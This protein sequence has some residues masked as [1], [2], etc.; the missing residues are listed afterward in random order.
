[1]VPHHPE[2]KS[3]KPFKAVLA[4]DLPALAHE[5][6]SFLLKLNIFKS[7]GQPSDVKCCRKFKRI[8]LAD[9]DLDSPRSLPTGSDVAQPPPVN[10]TIRREELER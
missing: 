4:N 3:H 8:N 7:P 10:V 2:W 1:M 5:A 9:L 6:T